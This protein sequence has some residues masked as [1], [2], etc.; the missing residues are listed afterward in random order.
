MNKETQRTLLVAVLLCVVCSVIVSS[1]AV[2]L[3]PM[4]EVNKKLDVKKNLLLASGLLTNSSASKDEILEIFKAVE[5]RI[6]DLSTGEFVDVGP[7]SFD[8]KKAA[9][10]PK[11]NILI[12]AKKDKG[13]IKMR[14]KYAK[15]YLVKD[16][17]VTNLIVLPVHGKGLWSTL[18]GFMALDMDGTTIRGLGFYE[19]GETPGLG[20]EV[21]NPSWKKQWIGK[22]AM[23]ENFVPAIK[24]IKGKVN[25]DSRN[26]KHEI[27]GLSGAT[28]TSNGVSNLVQYWLGEDGFG[29]FLSKVRQGGVL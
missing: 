29:P 27:D 4:Q 7:E 9:K 25:P 15:V 28:I 6:I 11:R 18:Y 5:P 12:D 16:K 23:D 13:N 10:D 21:D 17:G 3:K 1:A 22:I 24:V 2:L 14:A 19:H 26:A 8:Q 20:G